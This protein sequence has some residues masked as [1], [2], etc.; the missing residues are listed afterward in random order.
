MNQPMRAGTHPSEGDLVRFL[1]HQVTAEER[2]WLLA[3]LSECDACAAQL[4]ELGEQSEEVERYI[5]ALH[6]DERAD[7][8]TRARALAAARAA[9]PAAGRRRAL[10][11]AGW[12]RAAAVAAVAVGVVG[13]SPLRAWVADRIAGLFGDDEA[14]VEAVATAPVLSRGS[15]IAFSPVG[16]VFTLQFG[17]LQPAGAVELA[18]GEGTQ[19]SAQVVASAGE[20]FTLLPAGVVVNNASASQASYWVVVPASVRTVQIFAGGHLLEV[21]QV[22]E[23]GSGWSHSV[24]L[25]AR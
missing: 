18:L 15:E 13:A 20:S 10:P 12:V 21:V 23:G 9:A 3:H 19:I 1:D 5:A 4:R 2:R 8:L 25:R 11:G 17:R 6:A 22:P 7:E 14:A 24:P 16:E